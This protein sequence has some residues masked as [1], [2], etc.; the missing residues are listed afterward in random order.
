MHH[1]CIAPILVFKYQNKK[2]IISVLFSILLLIT[3][4]KSIP[5]TTTFIFPL[6]LFEHYFT[7][8][9]S[10]VWE[11]LGMH[12]IKITNGLMH[13]I[14]YTIRSWKWIGLFDWVLRNWNET[15]NISLHWLC[16][17]MLCTLM[18]NN[19]RIIKLW[20]IEYC[21]LN[22]SSMLNFLLKLFQNISQKEGTKRYDIFIHLQ[23]LTNFLF[24]I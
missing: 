12:L 11:I 2:N 9:K 22:T 23:L 13:L 7:T 15:C 24:G 5:L 18:S 19:T 10:I 1:R 4:R 8:C 3:K 21:T 14:S 20:H 17:M 6:I 16:E